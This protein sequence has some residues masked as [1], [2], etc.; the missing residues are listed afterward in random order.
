MI[1]A[2]Q[3]KGLYEAN[4]AAN[5]DITEIIA[6][7]DDSINA[8]AATEKELY[9]SFEA[10]EVNKSALVITELQKHGFYV[11]SDHFNTIEIRWIS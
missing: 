7:I 1:T 2:Q 9:Y 11:E 10:G 4:S 5:T 3:A 6:K 8:I